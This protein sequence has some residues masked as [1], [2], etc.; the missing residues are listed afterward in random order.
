MQAVASAFSSSPTLTLAI[1]VF[2][3]ALLVLVI[4]TARDKRR[5][6]A[7]P[8]QGMF[9]SEAFNDNIDAIADRRTFAHRSGAVL[10]ARVDHLPQVKQLWGH[11][12]RDAALAQ[13]AQVMRA[14][15]RKG[16]AVSASSDDPAHDGT[17][18]IQADGASE[19]EAGAIARRLLDTLSHMPVPGMGTHFRV[20][21]S[22]GV[23]G[24]LPGETDEAMRKRA[25]VALAAAQAA[26]EDH[27][28]TASEWEEIKLLPAPEATK[29]AKGSQAA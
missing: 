22:F 23:A 25:E 8:L 3:G 15:V 16:D 24:R 19:A 13:V 2:A 1:G 5:K 7:N 27:I 4:Q 6:R 11:D 10:R 28:V 18:E 9:Q 20:S 26:G 21:A 14:G 17:I 29:P 12:T